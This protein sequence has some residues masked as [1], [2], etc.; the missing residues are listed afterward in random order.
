MMT[1]ALGVVS[2]CSVL[3]LVLFFSSS[4]S[5]EGVTDQAISRAARLAMVNITRRG[6][7]LIDKKNI[8]R[9]EH[10]HVSYL[11]S[12]RGYMMPLY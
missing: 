10:F 12:S 9:Y 8:N 3:S 2:L 11:P 6:T 7:K 1:W 4:S 5:S